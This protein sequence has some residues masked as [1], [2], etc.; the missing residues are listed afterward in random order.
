[1]QGADMESTCS[2]ASVT[3]RK[4][5]EILLWPLQLEPLKEGVQ[6]QKHWEVLASL[7]GGSVWKEVEDEITG[8][9]RE[10]QERHYG[11]FV[12]FLPHVQRFLYGEGPHKAVHSKPVASSLR[13]FRRHD[14]AKIRILRQ[15]GCAP[16]VLDIAHIDLYFFYDLDVVILAVEVFGEDLPL[17]VAQDLLF[18]FGRAFPPTWESDGRGSTCAQRTE[19]L[20]AAG[21]VLAASDFGERAK[22]LEYVCEHRAPRIASH[23]AFVMRPLVLHTSDDPG[24]LRYRQLEYYR[25]PVMAYLAVDNPQAI[26]RG[27]YVRLALLTGPGESAELPFSEEYLRGFEHRFCYDRYFGLTGASRREASRML[28]CGHDLITVGN[29]ESAFFTGAETGFLA[30]FRHQ[31]FLL[32]LIAHLHK[33]ALLMMSS[34]LAVAIQELDIYSI[35]SVRRFKRTIRQTHETFLRFTH[36]YWFHEVSI[37]VQA[38][39]IFGMITR[40]LG[41]DELYREVRDEMVDMGQYLDSDNVRRQANVVVRLTVITTVGLIGTT[42]TGF[43][44]MNLIAEADSAL[45]VKLLYF[46]LVL[47]PVTALLVYTVVK[48]KRLSDFFE[49]VSDERASVRRKLESFL[50]VWDRKPGRRETPHG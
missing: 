46:L 6:I 17:D 29:Y 31:Y 11:E 14:I 5:R 12:T 20:D 24:P 28:T 42:V 22:Y 43:M 7:P 45:P 23:W 16:V 36:R 18:R 15:D 34:R 10:F 8:D 47:V 49:T 2:A 35:D 50:E 19:W 37:Q 4:F 26:S 32:F 25:M 21:N 9:P 40:H 13:V 39:E 3:V 33:A 48:S 38:R 27:D 41:N 30:Q 1:M 44:G